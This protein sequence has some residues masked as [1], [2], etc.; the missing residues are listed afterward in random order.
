MPLPAAPFVLKNGSNILGRSFAAI[1]EPLSASVKRSPR[2]MRPLHSWARDILGKRNFCFDEV[3][4]N[5]DRFHGTVD[6]MSKR[7]RNAAFIFRRRAV[8]LP[9]V[10]AR[11]GGGCNGVGCHGLIFPLLFDTE[12]KTMVATKG[13]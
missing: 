12:H 1:P 9:S 10:I 7:C 13:Q 6:L 11:N 8:L 3:E 4:Q 5:E 2:L